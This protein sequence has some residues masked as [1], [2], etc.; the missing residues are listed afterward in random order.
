M[1][2]IAISCAAAMLLTAGAALAAAGDAQ[3][4]KAPTGEDGIATCSRLIRKQPKS[5]A[6]CDNPATN[7]GRWGGCGRAQTASWRQQSFT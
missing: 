2:R 7:Y 3:T 6:A 5:V 4:C 1:Y